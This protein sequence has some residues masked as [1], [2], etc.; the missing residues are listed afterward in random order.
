MYHNETTQQRIDDFRGFIA[1]NRLTLKQVCKKASLNY[2]S[3]KS[4]MSTARLSSERIEAL[5]N[6]ALRLAEDK[7]YMSVKPQKA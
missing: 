2:F 7:V 1:K 4:N 6:A 5:E 3:V